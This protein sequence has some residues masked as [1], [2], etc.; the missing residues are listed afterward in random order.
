MSTAESSAK[1]KQQLEVIPDKPGVYQFY[2]KDGELIYVGK[3]KSLKKRVNSY[4]NR[5]EHE[6]NKVRV[7]VT[8]VAEIRHIVVN[9][10]SD[11]L[12]LENNLIKENQPRYNIL[13]KDDKTFPWICVKKEP[14]PRVFL[15]RKLIQDGSD[16]FGPYTSALMVRTLLTLVK[17]LYH[18]RNCSLSLTDENIS[19]GKFKVC[20]EYHIG[21]CLG[22]CV[23]KQQAEDYD[24]SIAQIRLILRGNIH[25]LISGLKDEMKTMASEYKFEEAEIIR[26]KLEILEKFQGKS[27]IVNPDI[28]DVDVFSLIEIPTGAIVN[29]IRVIRGSVVQSHSIELKKQLEESPA[30]LLQYAIVDLRNRLASD[31]PEIIL[32]LDPGIEWKGVEI[33]IPKIGDKKRLLELSERNAKFYLLEKEKRQEPKSKEAKAQH[34]L[35]MMQKDLRMNSLP[36]HIECFDN[37]NIQ[38]SNPVAACVVFRNGKPSNSEYRHFNVKTVTG[39]DDFASM[40]EIV[41]RRY[42]RLLAENKELP[43]LIVID[44][45]KGQLNAALSSLGKLELRGKITVIGIAKKLEEIYFPDDPVPLYLDK[46]SYSLKIIQQIR[47]EA[48]RFGIEFHRLKRSKKFLVSEL[49]N[50]DGIGESTIQ[51]ILSEYRSLENIKKLSLEKLQEIVG[52]SKGSVIYKYFHP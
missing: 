24:K 34:L 41:L 39:P 4:F 11:A 29:Y 21:N 20:L 37:S 16:Y 49:E 42:T 36:T 6:S 45:G 15:T 31:A 47:N 2:N 50:I 33:T 5:T 1:L 35:E 27:N 25:Q 52:N 12:L 19:K 46:N 23:G 14:F 40:Q 48:H 44:G 7:M 9:T 17:Q 3:A 8:R 26:R 38:G 32:P 10:E 28:R 30:E 51:L 18:L 43:Q 22:P 13:L